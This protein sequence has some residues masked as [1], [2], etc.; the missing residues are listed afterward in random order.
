MKSLHEK[1][2]EQLLISVLDPNREV[3]PRFQAYSVLIDDGRVITG[4]IREESANQI[5]L[6][7][8]GGKLTTIARDEIEQIKG[9]GYSLMPQGLQQQLTPEAMVEL[10]GWLRSVRTD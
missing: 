7:E 3:D 6:A 4:V 5:V 10:I 2:P 8:S 9:N 1:S